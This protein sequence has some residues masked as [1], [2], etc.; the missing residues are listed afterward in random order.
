VDA[1]QLVAAVSTVLVVLGLGSGLV[2][3][4][5]LTQPM[6]ALL[7]GVVLGPALGVLPV[8]VGDARPLLLVAELA[9]AVLLF[10][11]ASRVDLRLVRVQSGVPARMLLLALPLTVLL[12]TVAGTLLLGLGVG[13]AAV[14]ACL[15]APTDAALGQSLL[16]DE[17]VPRRLRQV[18]NV[19]SGLNDGFVV[20]LL[21]VALVV[22]GAEGSG[23]AAALALDAAQ[24]VGVGLLVGAGVGTGV[25]VAL[26][27]VGWRTLEPAARQVGGAATA[28][29]AWGGSELLGG[30]GFVAAFVCGIAFGALVDDAEELLE[31]S[32]DLGDLL[33]LLTFLAF[34]AL[35]VAPATDALS[36]GSVVLVVLSLTLLRMLPVAASLVGT[37][38]PRGEVAA[39]GWFGPRGLATVVFGLQV[40]ELADEGALA[41]GER[42][43]G[44]AALA[45]VA[46][47]VLHGA[48][49]GPLA[50]SL[51]VDASGRA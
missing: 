15:L 26:R 30:N 22:A 23:G 40:L 45:V 37:G 2:A 38:L 49:A 51:A 14:L 1:V 46:S 36:P 18:V 28:L 8:E 47:V 5:P 19:E 50:R 24:L 31:F 34:G 13:A 44:V 3:R 25:A 16:S 33:A 4:T 21:A 42:L 41:E 35:F 10:V 11:D 29:A 39:L 12:G 17:R 9:L 7:A 32:E 48:S 6:L 43:F 27:A 20:P